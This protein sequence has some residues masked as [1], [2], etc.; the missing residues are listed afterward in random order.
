MALVY[1]DYCFISTDVAAYGASSACYIFKNINFVKKK[2]EGNHLNIPGSRPLPNDD[3][4]TIVIVGDKSFALSQH[5]LRTHLN[6][7]LDVARRIY[8]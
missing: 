3:N 7:S 1:A 5:A 2:I 8:V 6:R 4:G